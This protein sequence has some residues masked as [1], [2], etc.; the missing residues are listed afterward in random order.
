MAR[1]PDSTALGY[2]GGQ[3]SGRAV[4]SYDVS[5]I[6]AGAEQFGKAA[7]QAGQEIRLNAERAQ[8]LDDQ[9]TSARAES[10]FLTKKV[11]IESSYK[12]DDANY[13][14]WTKDYNERIT[15]ARDESAGMIPDGRARELWTLKKNDD[16]AR[17]AADV[18]KM[19]YNRNKDAG[20]ADTNT[21]LENLRN[22]ALASQDEATRT[23]A[24]NAG[25]DL[26]DRAKKAGW[27]TDQ[28]AVATRQKWAKDYATAAIR[29]MPAAER[30]EALSG[31]VKLDERTKQAYDFF[32]SK[33]YAPAQAAGI[34]GNLV[35]ESGLNSAARNR[36]DGRDGSDSIGIGQWNSERSRAL[37]SFATARGKAVTDFQTQLEFVDQ[38][39]TTSEGKAGEALR[40]AQDARSATSAFI[41]FERPAGWS[42]GNPEGGHNYRGRLRHA[43]TILATYGGGQPPAEPK[44]AK[45]ASVLPPDMQQGLLNE[46]WQDYGQ[47]IRDTQKKLQSDAADLTV[48]MTDDIASIENSGKGQDGLTADQVSS[49]LGNERAREWQAERGRAQRVYEALDGIETLPASEVEQ[50]LQSLEPRPGSQ[51]YAADMATYQKAE[52]RAKAFLEARRADPALAVETFPSV[53]NARANAQYEGTEDKKTL[54][55]DSAQAIV[56]SRLAAQS[57]L[58]IA[59]PMAVTRSEARVIGRQLRYIGEDDGVGLNRFLSS[60]QRT[61]GE[62]TQA[63]LT[64]TLQHEGVNRDL[65]VAAVSVLNKMVTDPQAV[66]AAAEVLGV[67]PQPTNQ[68]VTVADNRP[69]APPVKMPA[70]T[71]DAPDL[72]RLYEGRDNPDLVA[73]FNQKYGANKAQEVLPD[74]IR[75]MGGAR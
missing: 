45:L 1:L 57:Q 8:R 19:V 3:D 25:S 9:V 55:P 21:Q 66:K 44:N 27:I 58:G 15:K 50:R 72:R 35:A 24:I 52:K 71:Y 47:T 54:T 51:G 49:V 69:A 5:G 38:E 61:Y 7:M 37:Q 42:P 65:S 10:N 2:G 74:L 60:L 63:V 6:G 53:K 26:I 31:P 41:G 13:A 22:T 36:G 16:I 18:D 59:D 73:G 48:K 68:P 75:R 4:A 29:L 30:I 32:V 23:Q 39:L 33:G 40:G 46:A 28:D 67:N 64:S 12:P 70:V 11:E 56:K 20:L 43:E 17:G 62:Q 34:V 14:N